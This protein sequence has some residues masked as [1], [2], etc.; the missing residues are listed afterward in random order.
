MLYQ[1]LGSL[2]FNNFQNVIV[3]CSVVVYFTL[4]N[5]NVL[6]QGS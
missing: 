2:K 1:I 5:L 6:S 4:E 3:V